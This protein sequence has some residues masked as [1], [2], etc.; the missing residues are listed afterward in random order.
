MVDNIICIGGVSFEK[1]DDIISSSS[2]IIEGF[3]PDRLES[4]WFL[5]RMLEFKTEFGIWP[6]KQK[7]KE[8]DVEALCYDVYLSIREEIDAIWLKHACTEEGCKERFA[9]IDGNMRNFIE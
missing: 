2:E 3:N 6:R 1:A 4:G 8:L 5:Y 9:V 7:S